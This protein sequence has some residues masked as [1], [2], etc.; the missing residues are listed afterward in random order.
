M[1]TTA[2]PLGG[3]LTL[4]EPDALTTA[5]RALFDHITA[6]AAPWARRSGFAA[7]TTDRR[8][9][10]PFNPNLLSPQVAAQLLTLQA[11]KEEHTSR[12]T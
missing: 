6:T 7:A 11:V 3:R 10:G 2:Q 8:L 1:S 9:I 12:D 4:A 5:Q